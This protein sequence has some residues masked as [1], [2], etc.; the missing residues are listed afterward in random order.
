VQLF[1]RGEAAATGERTAYPQ[2]ICEINENSEISE[3]N[4][5]PA[6]LLNGHVT[7]WHLA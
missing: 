5:L 7:T 2:V 3:I 6:I 1:V 4:D